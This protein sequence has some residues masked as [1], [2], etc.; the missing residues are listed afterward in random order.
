MRTWYIEDA[1]GGCRAFS[2]V[3]VLV[4]EKPR[5]IYTAL[6]PLTWQTGQT[7]EEVV[8]ELVLDMMTRAGVTREDQILVCSGN[9]FHDLHRYLQENH[10]N[11]STA[12]MEGLAHE[13]AEQ[14]FFEQI[15]QAGFPSYIKLNSR[16]Y[17]E[18]YQMVERWVLENKSRLQ[19]LKDRL[20]RQKPIGNKYCYKANRSRPR[21]CSR[22][23]N[24]ILPFTPMVE[25][26]I[27]SRGKKIH[28]YYHP[29]CSPVQPLKNKLVTMEATLHG[30]PLCGVITR[31][32]REERCALCQLPIPAGQTAFFGYHNEQ[33]LTVHLSCLN[34]NHTPAGA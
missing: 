23:H 20:V 12:R 31:S 27:N 28:R 32:N 24:A 13:I 5:E 26:R 21:H 29:A 2:E 33:L 1:G 8:L 7:L 10:Y 3:L 30:H 22:C 19:Y 6:V 14:V 16:N 11:W 4:S 34:V 15:V 17:R 9:I 25:C 18:F